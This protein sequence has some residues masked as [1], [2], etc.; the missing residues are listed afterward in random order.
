MFSKEFSYEVE[1]Y[2]TV[3]VYQPEKAI[4][5]QDAKNVIQ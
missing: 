5:Q 1:L 3:S 4:L 2:L